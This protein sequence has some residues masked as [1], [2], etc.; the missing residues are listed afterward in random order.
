M[1]EELV[2]AHRQRW[3]HSDELLALVLEKLDELVITFG[4]A[5]TAKKDRPA[6]PPKPYRYPRPTLPKPIKRSTPAEVLA[7]FRGG[8]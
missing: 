8:R 3:T 4:L 6:R 5:N 1:L 7:F 2:R